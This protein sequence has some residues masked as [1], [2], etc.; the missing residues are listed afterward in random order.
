MINAFVN[1][2]LF[3]PLLVCS[4]KLFVLSLRYQVK[5]PSAG[6]S[7]PG[8]RRDK[9]CFRVLGSNIKESL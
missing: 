3:C 5:E 7:H 1:T 4:I 8:F 9:L 6:M 2:I